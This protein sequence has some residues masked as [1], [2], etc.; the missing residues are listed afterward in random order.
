MQ[1]MSAADLAGRAASAAPAR[2]A[3]VAGAALAAVVLPGWLHG[4]P[5]AGWWAPLAALA[6]V[7]AATR[8]AS[9][10]VLLCLAAVAL[11]LALDFMRVPPAVLMSLCGAPERGWL[12]LLLAHLRMF[13]ATSA[14]ML[15]LL[16]PHYLRRPRRLPLLALEFA[17]MLAAMTLA[18][19]LFRRLAAPLGGGWGPDGWA[20]AMAAGMIG[21]E[22]FFR[23]RVCDMQ[24]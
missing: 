20:C 4:M 16:L 21:F 7:L 13:P 23:R 3:I 22:I 15:C 8:C 18:M 24:K 14:L 6:A 19:E 17:G 5:P 2:L 1:T 11:G 10:A 12:P 9:R